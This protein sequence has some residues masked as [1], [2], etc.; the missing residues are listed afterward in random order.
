M[1]LIRTCQLLASTSILA[2]VALVTPI[3]LSWH[4]SPAPSIGQAAALTQPLTAAVPSGVTGK[5]TYFSIPSIGISLPVTDGAY[6]PATARWTLT[7]DKA[8]FALPSQQPNTV[9]GNTLIYGHNRSSVF[10]SLAKVQPGA[11]AQVATDTGYVF[12]YNFDT[13]AALDPTDTSVFAYQGPAR[14]TV[15]TCSGNYFQHRQ[16]Y[17]F[18][19]LN[20]VKR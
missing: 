19:L 1:N 12:T 17:Y 18:H 11:I 8:Q 15:Q 9:A 5:P 7:R 4:H 16:M 14:L 6:D 3:G 10:A 13:T 20:V 2:G